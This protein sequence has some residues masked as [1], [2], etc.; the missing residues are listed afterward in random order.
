MPK[1]KGNGRSP[2]NKPAPQSAAEKIVKAVRKSR[3][4]Q[5]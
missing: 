1:G 2:K 3:L 4:F 5:V